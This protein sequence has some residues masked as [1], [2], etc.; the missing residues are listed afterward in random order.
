MSYL[1]VKGVESRNKLDE[2]DLQIIQITENNCE[3][4]FLLS[5]ASNNSNAIWIIDTKK[6]FDDK[7][8]P[9]LKEKL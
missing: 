2:Y 6:Q 5:L 9:S 8:L 1:F 7:F 3:E 4:D